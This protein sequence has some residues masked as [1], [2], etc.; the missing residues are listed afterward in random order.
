MKKQVWVIEDDPD[1]GEIVTFLLDSDGHQVR[2]FENAASFENSLSQGEKPDL[3]L[4][5]VM[6]PDGDG[7]ALCELVKSNQDL[8]HIPVMMM[9]AHASFAKVR[10]SCRAEEF[11]PKPFDIDELSAKVQQLLS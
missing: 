5:D 3:F 2:L 7:V 4:M 1:I 9:S 8:S 10:L 11:M 6:L